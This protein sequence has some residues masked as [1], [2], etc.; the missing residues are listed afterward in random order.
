MCVSVSRCIVFHTFSHF[1]SL[2]E[3]TPSPPQSP[4]PVALAGRRPRGR[5]RSDTRTYRV[6]G[7]YGVYIGRI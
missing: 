3:R 5:A 1:Q 7:V 4:P 2:S 6:V